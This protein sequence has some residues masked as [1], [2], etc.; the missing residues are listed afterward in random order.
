[1]FGIRTKIATLAIG[2]IAVVGGTALPSSA[3]TGVTGS[4]STPSI[5]CN[6][7]AA[8]TL[9]VPAPTVKAVNSTVSTD[10]QRVMFQPVVFKWNGT[11][12]AEYGSGSQVDGR[13][14][15]VS[16]PTTWYNPITGMSRGS[17]LSVLSVPAGGYY[18]VAYK[19]WWFNS[20]GVQSGYDYLWASGYYTMSPIGAVNP[21][22]YC[23]T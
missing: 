4:H 1:M 6:R 7:T 9:Y 19:M 3:A 23:T 20:S 16:S 13:A 15:D 14:S 18:A 8:S 11:A 10:Y 17:G 21:A 12:W 2:A 22:S 5:G